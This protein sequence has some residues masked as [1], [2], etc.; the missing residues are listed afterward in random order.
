M[1][2]EVS[3]DDKPCATTT[4]VVPEIRSDTGGIEALVQ[5]CVPAI[6]PGFV[7]RPVEMIPGT[8]A[9]ELP[10]VAL[11]ADG[12]RDANVLLPS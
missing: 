9:V 2:R 8:E 5:V 7:P 1:V 10:P 12:A 4:L 6:R 3:L 11:A